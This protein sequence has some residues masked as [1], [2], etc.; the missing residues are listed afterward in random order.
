MNISQIYRVKYNYNTSKLV[1]KLSSL[2][3]EKMR[4][5]PVLFDIAVLKYF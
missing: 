2:T 1:K 3:F 5:K 4:F